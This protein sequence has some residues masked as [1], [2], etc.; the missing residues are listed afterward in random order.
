MSDEFSVD[1]EQ[2]TMG[3]YIHQD[4]IRRKF[5]V[6]IEAGVAKRFIKAVKANQ[7]YVRETV[8]DL[9]VEFADKVLG[10]GVK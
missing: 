6:H 1:G 7:G 4:D 2:R 8:R 5:L 9:M 10:K 3:E